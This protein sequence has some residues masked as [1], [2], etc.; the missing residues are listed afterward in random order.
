M[1]SL[2]RGREAI[3]SRLLERMPMASEG[4][5]TLTVSIMCACGTR[6]ETQCES[7]AQ[8]A[9][10]EYKRLLLERC[11]D[12]VNEGDC[13]FFLMTFTAPSFGK[14]HYVPKKPG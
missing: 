12:L 5:L 9:Y 8:T 2:E 3:F 11:K 10:R 6:R 14:V 13:V 1:A 7:R 4:D